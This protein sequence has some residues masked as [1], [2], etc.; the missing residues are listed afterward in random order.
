MSTAMIIGGATAGNAQD[1]V[2]NYHI[3][4][5]LA[6]GNSIDGSELPSGAIFIKEDNITVRFSDASTLSGYPTNDWEI[7]INSGGT[8]GTDHFAI[9]DVDG[10]TNPFRIEAGARN[11]ALY[12]ESDGD[13]GFGTNNPMV[14]LHTKTGDSPT[15]RLEQDNS[16]GW[17]PQ[18]WDLAGNESNFF[19]RDVTNGSKLP[20][21]I[22][23]NAPTSSIYIRANEIQLNGNGDDLNLKVEG[24]SDEYLLFT[25]ASEDRVGVGTNTPE[26]KLDVNGAIKIGTTTNTI[27]G[28]LRFDGT[29]FQ[30]Y[31]GGEWTSLI[32][33]DEQELT[34]SGTD[35]TIDNGNTV[36][37][38]SM[39]TDVY[40]RIVA[41]ET[42]VNGCCGSNLSV[43]QSGSEEPS[44]LQN[45]PNPFDESTIIEYY[46]PHHYSDAHLDVFGIDGTFITKFNVQPGGKGY[47][48]LGTN[49]LAAG[50]YVYSLFADGELIG[51]KQMVVSR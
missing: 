33:T 9:N 35:L 27:E 6:V 15:L 40:N 42:V 48:V 12:V 47:V 44:L 23:P 16:S 10:T 7:E 29:D 34:L 30:G 18:S 36:D 1:F 20:F 13:V 24:V 25:L 14:D 3:D 50:N 8:S 19:I 51:T 11:N 41:I 39:L 31:A 46:L 22:Q 21:R 28:S 43:D 17:T 5:R 37:L 4:G 49:S 45:Y 32:N 38:S 26:V 2:G